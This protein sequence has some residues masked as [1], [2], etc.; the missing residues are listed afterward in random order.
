VG[1]RM[2]DRCPGSGTVADRKSQCPLLYA[3]TELQQTVSGSGSYF[4]D[5]QFFADTCQEIAPFREELRKHW[6]SIPGEPLLSFSLAKFRKRKHL[7]IFFLS[8]KRPQEQGFVGEN[9]IVAVRGFKRGLN[10]K[11]RQ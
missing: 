2:A 7:S 5:N 4:V 10:D 1:C 3:E 11:C 8:W 9:F 6:G